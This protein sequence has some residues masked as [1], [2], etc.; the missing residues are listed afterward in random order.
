MLLA[1]APTLSGTSGTTVGDLPD[2]PQPGCDAASSLEVVKRHNAD[3]VWCV[4]SVCAKNCWVNP[5]TGEARV[6]H[7]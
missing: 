6:P 3:L 2:C 1:S 5:K 7:P 4:C